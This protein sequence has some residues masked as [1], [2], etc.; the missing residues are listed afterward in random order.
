MSITKL[1]NEERGVEFRETILQRLHP[2]L[3]HT[4]PQVQASAYNALAMYPIDEISFAVLPPN[5]FFESYQENMSGLLRALI[6][7]ECENLGRAIFK[8]HNF[9]LRTDGVEDTRNVDFAASF[10]SMID[11]QYHSGTLNGIQRTVFA[12]F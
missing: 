8:G 4:D 12:S 11:S 2:Y 6:R 10:A 7:F 3:L 5:D 1:E 9:T